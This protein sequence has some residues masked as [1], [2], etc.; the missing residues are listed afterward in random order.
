MKK[1][2]WI[3][4]IA[5]AVVFAGALGLGVWRYMQ[6]NFHNVT[7][8][9][10]ARPLAVKHF[11]RL[12]RKAQYAT[13]VTD[14]S[15]IDWKATGTT[16]I[17]LKYGFKEET[18]LLTIRD[19]I[20]PKVVFV[21]RRTEGIDYIPQP[22]DFVQ[23][24]EDA[25]ELTYSFAEKITQPESYRDLTLTVIVTDK[26]GNVT[27]QKCVLSYSWLRSEVVL[28]LGKELTAADLLIYPD[29]DAQLISTED[30]AAVNAGGVGKYTIESTAGDKTQICVI[31]V[32][33]TTAPT[34]TLKEGKTFLG[35][36]I[37]P[38]AFIDQAQDISGQVK[39]EFVQ[40]PD[41]SK[42][43]TQEVQ[44]RF[45]DVYGNEVV[46][47]T[48]L[49]VVADT[50]APSIKF[51][52][53]MT[54]KKD[55][56]P[57]YMAG[58]SAY[59]NRDGSCKVTCDSSEVDTGKAG[60]YTITYTAKDAAGNVATKKRKIT[61]NPDANETEALVKKIAAGLPDDPEAIRDYVR[62]IKYTHNWGGD[63]P[64]W[65]GFSKKHGNCYVHALCL[66]ALLTEKGYE[67]QLIW[68]KGSK[69]GTEAAS[70]G[71]NAHYW[72]II[73]LD[74]GWKHIDATPGN[75]HTI[76]SLM[77]D[78]QRLETLKGREWDFSKWPACN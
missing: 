65:H 18:V 14:L 16:E 62:D 66:Q 40:L 13:F 72:L 70:N 17:A 73:K 11:L 75:T 32:V 59:D 10:G 8:E 1:R 61:V 34:V 33:D 71:W 28:E 64:V 69:V 7:V 60:T 22:E 54:V 57:D 6:P 47:K 78:A 46:H 29:K 58:V 41:W 3:T 27:Q 77:N 5:V 4:V 45:T 51:S 76:Y 50:E 52:G 2:V 55:A 21:E 25:S 43:G 12:Q 48:Q 19:T 38:E 20:A 31:S 9:L 39:A 37:E 56:Q 23:S 42:E 35:D 26:S 30:L 15:Q 63:D 74:G 67:T 44:I 68:V 53:D 36:A 49:T 24:A